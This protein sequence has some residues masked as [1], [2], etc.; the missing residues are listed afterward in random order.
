MSNK[1]ILENPFWAPFVVPT[2]IVLV[3]SLIVFGITTLLST[4]RNHRDLVRELHN[5][6]F[7]NRWVA[8][9]EL[10]K[11]ISSQ[12]IPK[13]DF[14][15]LIENL[16][17]LYSEGGDDLRTKKFV[18]SA[19]SALKDK[20]TAPFFIRSLNKETNGELL[21]TLIVGAGELPLDAPIDEEK[22]AS[23]LDNEDEGLRQAALLTLARRD[24]ISFFQ[25]K[26]IPLLDDS[27]AFVRYAAAIVLFEK[28]IPESYEKIR[29][30]T[31][32]KVETSPFD[33]GQIEAL[34]INV[35][36]SFR[37]AV[38]NEVAK[39]IVSSWMEEESSLKIK[40]ELLN[41][42]STYHL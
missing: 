7:G 20:R 35:I 5:K 12:K 31:K 11:Y 22:V 18:A 37:K 41:L 32:L 36:T 19:L 27:S 29:E 15:F 28:E 3:G 6:T 10:A 38:K 25:E 26:I 1:K 14:P 16:E 17:K 34:K 23:F 39:D 8:A 13:E 21:L 9:F 40:G 24:K 30:I 42:E 33:A 4:D 2:A